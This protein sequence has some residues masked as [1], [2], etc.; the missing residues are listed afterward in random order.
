M[1]RSAARG[2]GKGLRNGK[3]M[4]KVEMVDIEKGKSRDQKR[5]Q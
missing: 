4:G 3:E 1:G 5:K 2:G